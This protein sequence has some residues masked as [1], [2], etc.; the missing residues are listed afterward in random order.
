M[1]AEKIK[2]CRRA[3]A[4]LHNLADRMAAIGEL[5]DPSC[6]KVQL[7]LI[8]MGEFLDRQEDKNASNAADCCSYTV[9]RN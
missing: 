4:T 3:I 1:T 5:D 2:E 7:I 8:D 6:D 9:R